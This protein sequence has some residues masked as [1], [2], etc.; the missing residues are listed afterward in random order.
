MKALSDAVYYKTFVAREV[1]I[2]RD[3]DRDAI[4]PNSQNLMAAGLTMASSKMAQPSEPSV[5][6]HSDS[7]L[8]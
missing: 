6:N 7:E 3:L 8:H 2:E 4:F 5:E 1:S